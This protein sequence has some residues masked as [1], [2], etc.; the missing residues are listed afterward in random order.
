MFSGPAT[1]ERAAQTEQGLIISTRILGRGLRETATEVSMSVS[2]GSP[3]NRAIGHLNMSEAECRDQK[4][5]FDD[6]E[7]TGRYRRKTKVDSDMARTL[8]L[9]TALLTSLVQL[10]DRCGYLT[11]ELE[12]PFRGFVSPAGRAAAPVAAQRTPPRQ[13]QNLTSLQYAQHLCIIFHA[14][15]SACRHS[16][17]L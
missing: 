17:G 6:H 3:S 8:E 9:T 2:A 7:Y 16:C 1:A 5:F 12:E 4:R 15:M 14:L 13:P 11:G 10:R